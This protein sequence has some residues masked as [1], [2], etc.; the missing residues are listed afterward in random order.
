MV[1]KKGQLAWNKGKKRS[2]Y[3]KLRLS[4]THKGKI[5]W[6]KGIS[7][8]EETKKKLSEKM[9]G[10]FCGKD[11]PFYGKKHTE[12]NKEKNRLYHLGKKCSEETKLKLKILKLLNPIKYWLGKKLSQ[13]H[14]KK[15][16]KSLKGKKC[17]NWK[18][19]ISKL[20][21]PFIFNDLLKT[22]IKKRDNYTCKEC[23]TQ[24]IKKLC[25][26]HIDYNKENCKKNNLI[27]LCFKCNSKVNFNREIWTN[28]FRGVYFG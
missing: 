17:Y 9:K 24:N 28:Y 10:R 7:R 20:P 5:P 26:H 4:Q 12:E 14:K 21:Y 6:N 25:V 8:S 11:N 27:T 23:G 16:S 2:E 13:N 18:G 1:F 22:E 15:I 19:G 3:V